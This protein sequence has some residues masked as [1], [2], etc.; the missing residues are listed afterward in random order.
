MHENSETEEG[1]QYIIGKQGT[2]TVVLDESKY[3][4]KLNL[5]LE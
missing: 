1:Y 2:C 5:L 3:K 4:N